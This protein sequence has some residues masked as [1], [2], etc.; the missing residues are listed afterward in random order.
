MSLATNSIGASFAKNQFDMETALLFTTLSLLV[1]AILAVYDGFYLHIFKYELHKHHESKKEHL[2]HTWRAIFFPFILFTMFLSHSSKLIFY[3]G[4]GF[5]LI[6]IIV[7][8]VDAFLEKDSRRFMGGLPRWEYILHLFVNGFHFASVAL[9]LVLK[10]HWDE[11]GISLNT[12][13]S[14]FKNYSMLSFLVYNLLPGAFFMAFL[15]GLL[16]FPKPINFWSR[17]RDRVICC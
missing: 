1:F 11:K 8:T 15:H 7:M 3:I 5:V 9:I 2:T 6:D 4:L 10:L 17:L 16:I 12:D 13:L 14:S